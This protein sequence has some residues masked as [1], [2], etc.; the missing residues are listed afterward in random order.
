MDEFLK[1]IYMNYMEEKQMGDDFFKY[2]KEFT[3]K[4]HD[5]FSEKAYEDF[6]VSFFRLCSRKQRALLYRG[7]EVSH[8]HYGKEICP[9]NIITVNEIQQQPHRTNNRTP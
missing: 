8:F 9:A 7:H 2:F 6:I 1:V 5:T 3:D 4:M